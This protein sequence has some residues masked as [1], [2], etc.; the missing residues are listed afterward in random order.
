MRGLNHDVVVDE[1][2][3]NFARHSLAG[4][5]RRVSGFTTYG[6]EIMDKQRPKVRN[7]K[8]VKIEKPGKP[9]V[10]FENLTQALVWN[11]VFG[12]GKY[13]PTEKS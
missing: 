8:P 1:T 9:V 11:R 3:R 4:G 2:L 5:Y 6:G 7:G 12:Q 13:K 10:K